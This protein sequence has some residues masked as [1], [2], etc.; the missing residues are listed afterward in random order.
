MPKTVETK[1]ATIIYEDPVESLIETSKEIL[2][3]LK[4][5]TLTKEMQASVEQIEENIQELESL[6]EEIEQKKQ[7]RIQITKDKEKQDKEFYAKRKEESDELYEKRDDFIESLQNDTDEV[8]KK[9]ND[10]LEEKIDT[11]VGEVLKGKSIAMKVVDDNEPAPV[12]Q[13][14]TPVA[15]PVTGN[16][17]PVVNKPEL[18]ITPEPK[19]FKRVG[20][21]LVEP[22]DTVT[23][24]RRIQRAG[25]RIVEPVE[26]VEPD[27][28]LNK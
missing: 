3:E 16:T 4:G 6:E 25:G 2:K 13:S 12:T 17:E 28:K 23:E 10:K 18:P 21:R 22:T 5:Q 26:K 15:Q 11:K 9:I 20:G 1:E 27:N 14:D 19:R 7:A 24:P 8:V